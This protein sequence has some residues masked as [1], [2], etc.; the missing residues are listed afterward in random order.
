MLKTAQ[1]AGAERRALVDTERDVRGIS[2]HCG[3]HVRIDVIFDRLSPSMRAK[4]DL[5]VFFFIY[6]GAPTEWPDGRNISSVAAT[7]SQRY[8]EH[9]ATLCAV[10]LRAEPFGAEPGG[11]R[12]RQPLVSLHIP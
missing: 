8:I 1:Y 12:N 4:L 5:F 3:K 6:V 2:F 10:V 9:I 7:M 11:S